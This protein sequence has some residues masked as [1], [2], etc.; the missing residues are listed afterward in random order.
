M[1]VVSANNF[2]SD[3]RAV[4]QAI[5]DSLQH[6]GC[7]VELRA[8][9]FRTEA[10]NRHLWATLRD[11]SRQVSWYGKK[12]DEESWKHIF[13]SALGKQEVVPALD[14]QGFVVLGQS[15]SRMGKKKMADLITLAISFG[16]EKGVTF[17]DPNWESIMKE[18]AK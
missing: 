12:L 8:L 16:L 2:P 1:Y 4:N 18:Y 5:Q 17:S 15:T 9:D 6:G 10:Q 11:I 3:M 13:T 14:G 7:V